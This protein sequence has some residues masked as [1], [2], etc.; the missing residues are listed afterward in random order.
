LAGGQ[1]TGSYRQSKDNPKI[2][3]TKTKGD[4]GVVNV[5]G[6]PN[7]ASTSFW[8]YFSS[9]QYGGLRREEY[10]LKNKKGAAADVALSI[11]AK[12]ASLSRFDLVNKKY[13]DPAVG[14]PV[15]EVN[16]VAD[17]YLAFSTGNPTGYGDGKVVVVPAGFRV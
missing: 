10:D 16:A 4:G 3:E 5:Q 9:Q 15:W 2:W 17:M 12:G 6:E 14:L 8:N 1:D 7:A 11:T 13:G